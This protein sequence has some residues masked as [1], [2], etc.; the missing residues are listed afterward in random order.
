MLQQGIRDLQR[1]ASARAVEPFGST[2]SSA[3]ETP[4]QPSVMATA[5]SGM[6]HCTS[7]TH[8]SGIG[9]QDSICVNPA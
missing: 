5:G 3:G 2:R 9:Q 7:T 6:Y 8:A 1:L 4:W